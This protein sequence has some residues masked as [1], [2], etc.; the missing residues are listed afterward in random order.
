MSRWAVRSARGS[1][2][3][4][5]PPWRDK[6]VIEL[7]RRALREDIGPGDVTSRSL[8]DPDC[9]IRAAVIARHACVVAGVE[10]VR[11]ACRLAD[12]GVACRVLAPD[13]KAV[14]AGESVMVLSGKA[15]S[16]LAVERTALN[17][18][19][20]LTGI[21]T[22]TAQYVA[23]VRR[24]GTI[25][26]DTRKTTP[27]M[28]LLEKYAVRCGGGQNHRMGLYD[29]VLIKDN[30]RFLWQ[31][32]SALAEAVREARKKNPGVLIEVEVESAAELR[33]ALSAS[34]DWIMLDNM[35]PE[36]MKKCVKICAGRCR[37]EASGGINLQSIRA[38]AAAGVDA[39]SIGA[40]THSAPAADLS[41]EVERS[42]VLRKYRKSAGRGGVSD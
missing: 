41:L 5:G 21:S 29:M 31:K 15:R 16:I 9:R 32:A 13:G 36:L 14:K 17:F 19:Q 42:S 1:C 38:I 26:L 27:N 2:R 8:I 28:R 23:A 6:R 39:V 18:L 30:H 4:P 37:L 22:L 12:R 35:A 10:I 25:I 24:Y 40:L 7:V 34:P 33:D 11:L 20:R 3:R